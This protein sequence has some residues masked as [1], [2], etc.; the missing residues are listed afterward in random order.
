MLFHVKLEQ[1]EDGWIVAEWPT[2]LGCVTQG[3]NQEEAL[4]NIKEAI[5]AW[6]WAEDFKTPAISS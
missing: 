1:A 3:K 6:L 2:L 5:T 4:I